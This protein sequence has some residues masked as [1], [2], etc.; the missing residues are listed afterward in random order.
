MNHHH[1]YNICL[2]F[3][4]SVHVHYFFFLIALCILVSFNQ[5]LISML[6]VYHI[7]FQCFCH[8]IIQFSEIQNQSKKEGKQYINNS[9]RERRK[10]FSRACSQHT[11]KKLLTVRIN[12]YYYFFFLWLAIISN[13]LY[14]IRRAYK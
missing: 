6:N 14:G 7:I 9:F 10:S 2:L 8:S 13:T 5:M 12:Y 11:Q 4:L 1:K 3:S